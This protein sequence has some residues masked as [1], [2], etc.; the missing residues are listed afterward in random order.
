VAVR[1]ARFEALQLEQGDRLSHFT[2]STQHELSFPLL[3]QDNIGLPFGFDNY[4][5]I[6]YIKAVSGD[7][8]IGYT[9]Y[10]GH[11]HRSPGGDIVL[12]GRD[13]IFLRHI[14]VENE[15]IENI[16]NDKR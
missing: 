4:R 16:E 12:S 11:T 9:L 7:T 15:F 8:T 13:W 3:K 6:T 2:W 10:V 5:T 14:R 1:H